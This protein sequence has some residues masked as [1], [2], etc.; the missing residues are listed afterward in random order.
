MDE[1]TRS[2]IRAILSALHEREKLTEDDALAVVRAIDKAGT[3]ACRN[4][5][6]HNAPGE[7]DALAADVAEDLL[8]ATHP[9]ALAARTKSQTD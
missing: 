2:A 8:G 9:T 7:L 6:S 3:L 5:R 1:A 4:P